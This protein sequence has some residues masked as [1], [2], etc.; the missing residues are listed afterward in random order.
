MIGYVRNYG[1]YDNN[2]QNNNIGLNHI[3]IT[4]DRSLDNSDYA[5][6]GIQNAVSGNGDYKTEGY[7]GGMFGMMHG[8]YATGLLVDGTVKDRTIIY[9]N[10]T[11]DPNTACVGGLIGATRFFNGNESYAVT[12]SSVRDVHVAGRAYV[13]SETFSSGVTSSATICLW[14]AP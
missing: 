1:D 12:N 13:S 3:K 14:R 6:Y 10:S 11:N 9:F 4:F 5:V 8:G 2:N 7:V